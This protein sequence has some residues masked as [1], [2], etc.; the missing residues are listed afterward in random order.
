M[1]FPSNFIDFF[2]SGGGV[3]VDNDD[4]LKTRDRKPEKSV[5]CKFKDY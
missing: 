4:A 5:N 2:V 1:R 3:F